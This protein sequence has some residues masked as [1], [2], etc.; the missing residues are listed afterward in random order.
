MQQSFA[1]D[2]DGENL[3]SDGGIHD[4]QKNKKSK[5]TNQWLEMTEEINSEVQLIKRTQKG[6]RVNPFYLL[7]F[8][9]KFLKDLRDLPLWSCVVRDEFGFGSVPASSSSVESDFHILKNSFLKTEVTPMRVDEYVAKYIKYLN[10]R[11]KIVESKIN[12]TTVGDNEVEDSDASSSHNADVE[13]NSCPACA[14]GDRPTGIHK[15]F[16]CYKPVHNLDEC[17]DPLEIEEGF[18]Q[19]RICFICKKAGNIDVIIE[20]RQKENWRNQTLK[21]PATKK[22]TPP[23][24]LNDSKTETREPKKIAKYYGKKCKQ[25]NEELQIQGKKN[26]KIAILRNGSCD[27]LSPINI[28]GNRVTAI[29]TCA[30]DSVYHLL[31]A[32]I[33]D[34]SQFRVKVSIIFKTIRL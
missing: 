23:L 12:Q 32:A 29:Y 14:N 19:K 31:A 33:C 18:G 11:L 16:I 30:F 2:T 10:G 20:S 7:K 9:S 13:N 21:L 24:E 25:I 28:D 17:S 34:W 6:H 3:N 5:T 26:K 15:C 22:Q 1:Y 27:K 4:Q 8:T